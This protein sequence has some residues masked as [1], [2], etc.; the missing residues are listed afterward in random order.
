MSCPVIDSNRGEHR[1]RFF[2]LSCFLS[3]S[4]RAAGQDKNQKR[5]LSYRTACPVL[6]SGLKV[7]KSTVKIA[8]N[9]NKNDT[10]FVN[11]LNTKKALR[12][13]I[14]IQNLFATSILFNARV[15]S[16]LIQL[17]KLLFQ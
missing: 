10:R 14:N 16:Y 17:N 1:T 9:Q 12:H 3:S 7:R 15:S 8:T 5:V 2:V 13:A 11:V 4:W 6:S